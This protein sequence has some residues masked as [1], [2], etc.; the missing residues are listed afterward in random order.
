MS[1]WSGKAIDV[2]FRAAEVPI[3][4]FL[5]QLVEV[6]KKNR[7]NRGA[8]DTTIAPTATSHGRGSVDSSSHS[9]IPVMLGRCTKVLRLSRGLGTASQETRT[10]DSD[11]TNL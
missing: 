11:Q 9:R 7:V 6:S 1:S 5:S 4:R 8:R 10:G 2:T 3:T